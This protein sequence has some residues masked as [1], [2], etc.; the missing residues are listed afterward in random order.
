M[1]LVRQRREAVRDDLLEIPAGVLDVEAET[2]LDAARRELREETGYDAGSWERLGAIHSSPG[3]SDE[4]V[5]LFVARG[6][7]RVAEPEE[8]IE[9]VA[10]AAEEAL[11]A[12]REGRITDAKSAVALLL[13]ASRP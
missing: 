6:A 1:I 12:V 5:E 3:F 2:P 9:V 8:G 10:I 13:A 11:R 4:R 7:E